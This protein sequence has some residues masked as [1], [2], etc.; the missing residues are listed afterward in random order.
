MERQ[1]SDHVRTLRVGILRAHTVCA[2]RQLMLS[3]RPQF[4]QRKTG[5]GT[6]GASPS[7][8]HMASRDANE[9]WVVP[10][11][12]EMEAWPATV[13]HETV[14]FDYVPG[15]RSFGQ[16]NPFVEQEI[17]VRD[18]RSLSQTGHS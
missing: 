18:S 13:S 6:D 4:M 7:A 9:E 11:Y 10:N 3:L 14:F 12:A 16:L 5:G 2:V 1:L 8:P 15:R 17:S